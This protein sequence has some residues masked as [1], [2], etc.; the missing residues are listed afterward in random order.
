MSSGKCASCRPS[1]TSFAAATIASASLRSRSP[2]SAFASATLRFTR[3]I[4][5][6]KTRGNRKPL[7]G[8]FSTARCVCGPHRASAGTRTSPIVSFST[9]KSTMRSEA[10]EPLKRCRLYSSGANGA[11]SPAGRVEYSPSSGLTAPLLLG[12]SKL[13]EMADLREQ[14]VDLPLELRDLALV[15]SPVRRVEAEGL[16]RASQ[17]VTVRGLDCHQSLDPD[18]GFFS[19]AHG[20]PSITEERSLSQSG[21]G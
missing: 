17:G 14:L 19:L 3:A 15:P 11:P 9:R 2:S 21:A 4:D 13:A 10:R 1:A 16:L 5:S 7:I 8:K 18:V 20:A 12:R 6:M